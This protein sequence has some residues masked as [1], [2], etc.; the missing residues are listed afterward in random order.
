MWLGAKQHPLQHPHCVCVA[1]HYSGHPPLVA[2]DVETA[3]LHLRRCA[4]EEAFFA[5]FESAWRLRKLSREA[6]SRIRAALPASARWLVDLAR[7]DADSGLESLLRLRLHLLGL[8]L[9]RQVTIDGVGRV[10]FVI[11]ARLIVEADGTEN[12]DSP[13]HR[14]RD[15]KRDAQASALGYETLRFDYAQIVHDWPVVQAAILGARRRMRR[16]G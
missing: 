2:T 3:L 8:T 14:H 16:I 5:A 6:R 9:E 4:G 12:H 15:R 7:A 11:A 13:E 1:H 10:D